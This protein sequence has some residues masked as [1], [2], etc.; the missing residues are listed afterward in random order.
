M[1]ANN[2][3]KEVISQVE[4]NWINSKKALLRDSKFTILSFIVTYIL[5]IYPY[6]SA[7]NSNDPS[8]F[9]ALG[10]IYILTIPLCSVLIIGFI[11]KLFMDII[12]FRNVLFSFFGIDITGLM[13]FL[14]VG[15]ILPGIFHLFRCCGSYIY[16]KRL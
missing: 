16:Y 4:K 9:S 6:I 15:F 10:F 14:S 3:N 12:L 7:K 2:Q 11:S 5:V 8:A 13:I 1:M